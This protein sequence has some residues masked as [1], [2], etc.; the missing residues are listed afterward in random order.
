M[1]TSVPFLVAGALTPPGARGRC[2]STPN[3]K[4]LGTLA[5]MAG[6]GLSFASVAFAAAN[7]VRGRDELEPDARRRPHVRSA[8]SVTIGAGARPVA[9]LRDEL[10]H[11][12]CVATFAGSNTVL[13]GIM[14]A[15][16]RGGRG[17][18]RSSACGPW[19]GSSRRTLEEDAR[20]RLRS[21]GAAGGS[22][23]SRSVIGCR[24]GV[25]IALSRRRATGRSRGRAL[26]ARGRSVSGTW[27]RLTRMRVQVL[28]R[29]RIASTSTSSTAS[30]AA[31]SGWRAF[32][33]SRPASASSLCSP[34]RR[35]SAAASD[36]RRPVGLSALAAFLR[37][38]GATRGGSPSCLR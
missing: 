34:W 23:P 6:A 21:Q 17:S 27:R 7:N 28:E 13:R 14:V 25:A 38:D 5:S 19:S 35:R 31:A 22:R 2:C 29:P 26:P 15:A 36:L 16:D 18:W 37:C 3:E 12:C 9:A 11:R 33:R 8:C 30:F 24:H 4:V 10:H 1:S 32:Q 20:A